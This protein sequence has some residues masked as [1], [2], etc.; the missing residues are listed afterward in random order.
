MARAQTMPR[1]GTVSFRID[2]ALKAEPTKPARQ[3]RKSADV[4]LRELAHERVSW[5]GVA[6]SK[7]TRAGSRW[8]SPSA[9]ATWPATR[10]T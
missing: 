6:N 2:P 7:P 1:G 4:L 9:A 10:P 5:N 8:T 3:D